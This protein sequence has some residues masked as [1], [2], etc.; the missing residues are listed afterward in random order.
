MTTTKVPTRRI[1]AYNGPHN[2][3]TAFFVGKRPV[4]VPVVGHVFDPEEGYNIAQVIEWDGALYALR[5]GPG[6]PT[7]LGK[8]LT[9][10]RRFVQCENG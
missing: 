2:T 10:E 1:R 6:K 4:H 5:E 9:G 8:W 7:P 3:P